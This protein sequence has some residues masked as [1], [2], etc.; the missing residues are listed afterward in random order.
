MFALIL[1]FLAPLA[2]AALA[3]G[4]QEL[5]AAMAGMEARLEKMEAVDAAL[6]RVQG[7]WGES[8]AAGNKPDPCADPAA[9]SLVARSRVLGGAY[10]DAVQSSRAQLVRLEH[11]WA[12]PTVS[13][14]LDDDDLSRADGLRRTVA[15]HT[16]I[17]LEAAAWQDRYLEPAARKCD[18]TLAKADGIAYPGARAVEEK[19][20]AVAIVAIGGGTV[21][22][23][24]LPADGRVVLA[25]GG[26]ACLGTATCSCTPVA[27]LP[28]AVLGP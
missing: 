26:M 17:W 21:C 23:A 27:V 3:P 10:R 13:P 20:A 5:D 19:P 11:L 7:V 2:P 14:L 15:E 8:L 9:A 25:P 28:A 18:V 16:L 24:N 6:G 1:P 4:P 12:A 22:P